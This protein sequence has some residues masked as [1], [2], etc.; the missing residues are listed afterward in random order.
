[1]P[2]KFKDPTKEIPEDVQEAL[3]FLVKKYEKEDGWVR[4]QQIKLWKKNAEF[5]HGI[6][7]IFWSES[8]QDWLL[9]VETRWFQEDEGREGVEGPFYDFVINIYRA[10]GESI[11]SALSAQVPAVRFP[12]DDAEDDD[13]LLTSKTYAK[14]ADLIQKHNS[15]RNLMLQ[16][17]LIAWNQGNV[18]WYH[19]PKTDKTF[20]I[21]HIENYKKVLRCANCGKET[22]VEDEEDVEISGLHQCPD[23]GFPLE[24]TTVLDSIQ[25]SPKSRVL[26]EPYGGLHVK[27]GF[28]AMD[29]KDSSYLILQHDRPKPLM[30]YV[31]PWIAEKIDMTE[32]D[33]H[34]Y[35]RMGRTPSS[36]TSF[37]RSDDNMDLV[38]HRQVWLRNWTYEGLPPEKEGTKKKLY[39][40]FPN[41][42]YVAEVG[43]IFAD[44]DDQ[45]MDK[46]WSVFKP[47]LA[48][49]LHADALGQPLIP[50]QEL[51]NINTNLTA[52][53][54]EQ[55]IGSFFADPDVLNFSIYSKHEARPGYIYPA[56][57][58]PGQ[59]L[60]QSF[61]ETGRATLSKEVGAFLEQLDKD[62]QFT[63]GDYPSLYGGPGEVASRTLGEYQ[64]SRV[65]SLQRL[66]I[67]WVLFVGAWARLMEKCVHI[68]VENLIEDER[69]VIPDPNKKDNYINVWIRK[70]DMTGHVG[71]VEPVGADSF[72]MSIPQRQGLFYQ[73]LQ[74]NNQFINQALFDPQNRRI[75]ADLVGFTDLYMPGEEQ[76]IQQASEIGDMLK[77]VPVP[78]DPIVDD[79]VIHIEV[80]RNFLASERGIELKKTN[81]Q[82]YLIIKQHLQ[83]HLQ[84]QV[85]QQ[86]E[87]QQKMAQA[88]ATIKAQEQMNKTVVRAMAPPQ[89][90]NGATGQFT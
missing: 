48:D 52:E 81:P 89:P 86:E 63:V 36:F 87:N 65:Q 1:M 17:F 37:N 19:A 49:Y 20:G 84:A 77:G 3:T 80:C 23:C 21:T 29:L 54:V 69:F 13:D 57:P 34:M 79:A 30:K 72:P 5:W 44:A 47:G 78:I 83:Q 38:T 42:V 26:I 25:D 41:G 27:T 74:L 90:R 68:Y 9:P 14:I 66:S 55:S 58:R 39:K 15:V 45:D 62:G 61:F 10:H 18:Y 60:D 31:Y 76:Q 53:T 28:W 56:R 64:Q 7:Y 73:L 70:A 71:E 50:V 40:M 22:P 67:A 12:P 59:A 24:E 32:S 82:T 11:I 88:Y 2:K 51:R 33:A 85:Q 43:K 8:R 4:K 46:Y 35:E 6:Q 16:S 75:I